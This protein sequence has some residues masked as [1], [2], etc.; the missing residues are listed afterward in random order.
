M[1]ESLKYIEI[2]H[3]TN[4]FS[5]FSIALKRSLVF[6]HQNYS[7]S[8]SYWWLLSESIAA[9]PGVGTLLAEFIA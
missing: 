9:F 5:Q 6:F 8:S 7:F 4:L 2:I 3:E 1:V